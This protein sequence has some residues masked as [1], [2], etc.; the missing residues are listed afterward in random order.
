M[1]QASPPPV[2]PVL[3]PYE[4]GF[5]TTRV[6]QV[7]VIPIKRLQINLPSQRLGDHFSAMI[8]EFCNK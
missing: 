2:F 4:A 1:T 5:L 8:L 7:D 3:S 6:S